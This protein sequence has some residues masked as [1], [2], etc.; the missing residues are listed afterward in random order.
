VLRYI[1]NPK[2]QLHKIRFALVGLRASMLVPIG[3]LLVILDLLGMM[4]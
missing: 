4:R 2:H 1:Q 3:E